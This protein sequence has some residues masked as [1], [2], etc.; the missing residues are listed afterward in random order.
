MTSNIKELATH[1][2]KY[3]RYQPNGWYRENP[4]IRYYGN[5]EEGERTRVGAHIHP[6][7]TDSQDLDFENTARPSRV[8]QLTR[9]KFTDGFEN[10]TASPASKRPIKD[11]SKTQVPAD[12]KGM[13]S[14]QIQ[15][16][17]ACNGMSEIDQ[18]MLWL[19]YVVADDRQRKCEV[20][21]LSTSRY[22]ELLE[23]SHAVAARRLMEVDSG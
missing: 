1:W 12:V 22:S 9:L 11:Y 23:H 14:D 13:D 10:L 5:R 21:G 8:R 18:M 15:F 4:C 17:R 3:M 16:R 2:G 20:I 19:E 7:N 6:D